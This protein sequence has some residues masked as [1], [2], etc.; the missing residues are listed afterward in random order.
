MKFPRQLLIKTFMADYSFEF[1][2]EGLNL[3]FD[4]LEELEDDNG[5][6]IEFDTTNLCLTYAENTLEDVASV[7]NQTILQKALRALE[8]PE[9]EDEREE[10]TKLAVKQFLESK[11]AFIG[12]TD[13]NTVVYKDY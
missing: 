5:V 12:F 6:Q 13:Q 4:Y 9:D 2:K 8:D 7:A 1:S 3:L 10:V 11:G